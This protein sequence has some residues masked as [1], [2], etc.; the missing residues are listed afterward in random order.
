MKGTW[1]CLSLGNER[2]YGPLQN[3]Q[4]IGRRPGKVY[5]AEATR[6]E[7]REAQKDA[8][9]KAVLWLFD[10]INSERAHKDPHSQPAQEKAHE[11]KCGRSG[12]ICFSR[13]AEWLR[14]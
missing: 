8:A 9:P 5:D 7:G 4:R 12:I 3:Y 14:F 13:Q 6:S 10:L 11:W 2:Y 1:A